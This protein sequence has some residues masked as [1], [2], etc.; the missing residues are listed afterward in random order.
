MRVPAVHWHCGKR[1]VG[2]A[3]NS[4][5]EHHVSYYPFEDADLYWLAGNWVWK[6]L[7]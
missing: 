2:V 6:G 1:Q 3:A 5:P 7:H 4:K